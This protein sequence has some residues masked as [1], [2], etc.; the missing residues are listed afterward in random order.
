MI[1]LVVYISLYIGILFLYLSHNNIIAS[2]I[3]TIDGSMTSTAMSFRFL[4]RNKP[5]NQRT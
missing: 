2:G 1:G 3:I 5:E 4:C